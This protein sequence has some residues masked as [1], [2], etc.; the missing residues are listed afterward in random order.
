MPELKR[1]NVCI[2]AKLHREVKIR[3]AKDDRSVSSILRIAARQ[4]LDSLQHPPQIRVI[5]AK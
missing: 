4:Y 2:P 5:K 3:A 1:I